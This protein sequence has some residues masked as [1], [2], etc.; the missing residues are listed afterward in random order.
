MM[1]TAAWHRRTA[2]LFMAA[3]EARQLAAARRCG[4]SSSQHATGLSTTNVILRKPP[5]PAVALDVEYS[6]L[7]LED[8]SRVAAPAWVALVGEGGATLL[9]SHVRPAVR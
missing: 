3:A 1:Q 4:R 8:G 2:V 6:H 9:K 7:L 5:S